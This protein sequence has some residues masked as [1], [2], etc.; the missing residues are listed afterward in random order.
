MKALY[1]NDP[2]MVH[3][4]AEIV[5][6]IER[7]TLCGVVLSQTAFYPEGG[8]QLSDRGVI[9]EVPVYDVQVESGKI[10][11]FIEKKDAQSLRVGQ[12]VEG[13]INWTLRFDHMQH[14]TGQHLLSAVLWKLKNAETFSVHF[15]EEISWIDVHLSEMDWQTAIEIEN[16][17]N[18]IVE[19]NRIVQIHLV[20]NTADLDKFPI[21]GSVKATDNIRIVE[22]GSYDFCACGGTHLRSTGEIGLI[23]IRK[24]QKIKNGLRIEYHCGR[25]ALKDYQWKNIAINDLSELLKSKDQEVFGVV[26]RIQGQNEDYSKKIQELTD[27]ICSFEAQELQNVGEV[28]SDT[29]IVYRIYENRP[30]LD[31]RNIA[32]QIITQEKRLVLLGSRQPKGFLLIARSQAPP[33]NLNDILKKIFATVKGKGGGKPDMVQAAFEGEMLDKVI[34]VALDNIKNELANNLVEKE[35]A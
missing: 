14:H 33:L 19:E 21:R 28:V 35:S 13:N 3:F 32:L 7:E 23:K 27:I 5:E 15:G 31:L 9:N 12:K 30:Q 34:K 18:G 1:Q 11:H 29:L 20:E 22:I 16:Q 26:K 24:W 4:S 8:G 25:R 6:F 17:A 10:V 2:Y